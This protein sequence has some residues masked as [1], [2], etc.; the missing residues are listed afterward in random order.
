M[1]RARGTGTIEQ[2]IRGGVVKFYPRLP[3]RDRVPLDGFYNTKAEADDALDAALKLVDAGLVHVRTTLDAFGGTVIDRRF[4]DGYRNTKD[5]RSRWRLYVTPWEC[6]SWPIEDVKRKHVN[7]WIR[8]LRAKELA[9]QTIANA[10]NLLRA[11]FRAAVEDEMIDV[12]PCAELRVKK[13]GRVDETSTFLTLAEL[14]ALLW[15]ADDEAR[16][17]IAFAAG[18]GLRQGEMRSLLTS[19]VHLDGDKHA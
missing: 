11:V 5:E 13:T 18:S 14:D 19:D 8:S 12:N 6:A 10:A 7:E 16:H 2:R 9:S 17:L 1:R 3:G 15:C 4:K